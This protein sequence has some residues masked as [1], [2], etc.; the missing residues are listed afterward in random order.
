MPFSSLS[1]YRGWPSFI[2][3]G[4]ILKVKE[5]HWKETTNHNSEVPEK[6]STVRLYRVGR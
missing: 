2:G 3:I 6:K 5:D 4:S 1:S